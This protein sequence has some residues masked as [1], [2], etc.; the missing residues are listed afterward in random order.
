[1]DFISHSPIWK[2]T[3]IFLTEDDAQAS[4]DHV[5]AHRSYISVISPWANRGAVVHS[6]SSTVSVPKTIEEILNLPAMSYGDMFANDLLDH[7]TTTPDFTP[8]TASTSV[9]GTAHNT[10]AALAAPPETQRIWQLTDRLD[11]TTYDADNVR[12][13][14]LTTLYFASLDLA[15]HRERYTPQQYTKRQD[16]LFDQA[17]AITT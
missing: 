16:T 9:P 13:G 5:S 6:L 8:F 10:A 3:A 17:R 1:V 2:S 4:P 15:K 11:S 7:F 14:Q 12:L